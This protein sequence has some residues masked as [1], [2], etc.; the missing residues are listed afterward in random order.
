LVLTT[1]YVSADPKLQDSQKVEQLEQFMSYLG[2]ALSTATSD[3]K[4][5]NDPEIADKGITAD[6]IITTANT[7]YKEK[8]GEEFMNSSVDNVYSQGRRALQ[9]SIREIVNE[10]QSSINAKGV[11]FKGFIPA[12]FRSKVSLKFNEKMLGKM[13]FHATAPQGLLRNRKHRPDAWEDKVMYGKFM[14]ADYPKNQPYSESTTLDSKAT[15]RYIKPMYYGETCL[16]CHGNKKGEPDISGYPKEGA[17]L[18]DFAGAMSF[19]VFE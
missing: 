13:R 12:V 5:I 8:S 16:S 1:F 15:F 10:A 17:K 11:G 2:F 3:Q 6:K 18:D 19:T 9:E 4:L 7:K 14:L